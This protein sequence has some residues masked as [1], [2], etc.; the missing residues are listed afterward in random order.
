MKISTIICCHNDAQTIASA[1]QS[2]IEQVHPNKELIIVDR[3]SSDESLQ[4]IQRF[5]EAIDTVIDT[6]NMSYF[7]SVN[8]GIEISTGDSIQVLHPEDFYI[9]PL[10]FDKVSAYAHQNIVYGD[11]TCID[12]ETGEETLLTTQ[13]YSYKKIQKGWT[14][15]LACTFIPRA[16]LN[17]YGAF[18]LA[19]EKGTTY[20]LF[21]RLLVKNE[22]PSSYM[23]VSVVGIPSHKLLKRSLKYRWTANKVY[24]LAWKIN[25]LKPSL[26]TF[27]TDPID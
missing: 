26:F 9:D 22:H 2:F 16:S 4:I 12:F 18:N 13:E 14:L 6:P 20:E 21:L 1:I 17:K 15:P 24:K 5:K 23:N 7:E 10:L 8:R 27:V 11:Q 3:G 25:K 19:M